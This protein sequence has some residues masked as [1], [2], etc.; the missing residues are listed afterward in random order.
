MIVSLFGKEYTV[1]Y[2]KII[3][4]LILLAITVQIAFGMSHN[5]QRDEM[6]LSRNTAQPLATAKHTPLETDNMYISVYVYGQVRKPGV[7]QLKKGSLVYDALHIAG[8]AKP[9]ANLS[10][11]LAWAME[12]NMMIYLPGKK[13]GKLP[14]VSSELD[15]QPG[16]GSPKER[17]G[18]KSGTKKVDINKASREELMTVPWVGESTADRIIEFRENEVFKTIEDIKKVSGIAEGKFAKMKDYITVN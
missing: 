12:E 7:Y 3:L 16:T 1:T 4:I 10:L 8:G 6:V 14:V 15:T 18:E 2:K 5:S 11:N 13:S 9:D 17:N